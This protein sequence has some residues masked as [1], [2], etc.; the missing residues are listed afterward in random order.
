MNI[1]NIILK[2]RMKKLDEIFQK[3][4]VKDGQEVLRPLI[5]RF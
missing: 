1:S 4:L 5:N 3:M 2:I